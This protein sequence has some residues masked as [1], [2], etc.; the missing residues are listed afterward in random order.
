MHAVIE[1]LFRFI[2]YVFFCM[3]MEIL[4][5][6]IHKI[7]KKGWNTET[8]ILEGNFSLLMVIPYGLL[9]LFIFEPALKLF[10]YWPLY[11]KFFIFGFFFTLVELGLGWFFKKVLRIEVWN[12]SDDADNIYKYTRI[13]LFWQWVWAA[14]WISSYSDTIIYLSQFLPAYFGY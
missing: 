14:I 6:A 2:M 10:A 12:Y 1:Y 7:F 9:L 5:S 11:I 3:G 4:V 8:K 13:G